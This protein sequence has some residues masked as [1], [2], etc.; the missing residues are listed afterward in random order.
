MANLIVYVSQQR[1][2][3]LATTTNQRIEI[4]CKE[5]EDG[6]YLVLARGCDEKSGRYRGCV[7]KNHYGS[8]LVYNSEIRGEDSRLGNL[9]F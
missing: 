2:E 4:L 9:G 3:S 1:V 8:V 7:A 5:V 6:F